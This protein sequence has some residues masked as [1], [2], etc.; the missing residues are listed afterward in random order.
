MSVHQSEALTLRTYRFAESHKIAVF[1][2]PRF[3]LLRAAAYGAMGRRHRYGSSLEALTLLRLSFS[4]S[5]NR[6]LAT[7]R[8]CEIIRPFAAYGMS[9][10]HSLYSGYFVELFCEFA[11]ERQADPKLFRLARAVSQ[12]AAA[13][14]LPRLA[15]YLELWLLQLEGV[16]P[17]LDSRM[18][19]QLAVKARGLMKLPPNRLAEAELEAGELKDLEA[20]NLQMIEYHLERRLKSRKLIDELL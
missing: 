3:G 18:P 6:D 4:I 7:I 2:T 20:V 8:N 17:A 13:A 15:R 11:K 5:E 16:L 9:L 12:D 19:R 1:L 10:E 14:P